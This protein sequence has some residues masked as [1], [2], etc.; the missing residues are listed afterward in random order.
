MAKKIIA[1]CIPFVIFFG[2]FWAF[3]YMFQT[4]E[5]YHK[6]LGKISK[7]YE[8]VGGGM[9]EKV[10]KPY[11]E[12]TNENMVQWDGEH[13]KEIRD[14]GYK[15]KAEV[16]LDYIFAFFPLFPFIW[17]I[18]M[19]SPIGV[20]FL[21]FFLFTAG[22]LILFFLFKKKISD[23]FLFLSLPLVVCFLVPHTEA[24]FFLMGA[25]ALLGHLKGKYWLYFLGMAL[26]ALTRNAFT[27]ILPAMICAEILFFLQ[28]RN[29]KSS[30][31]RLSKA[32]LPVITGTLVLAIIQYLQ[33]S[34][35]F[36]NFLT[37]QEQWGHSLS[38]P[39]L[40]KL[41]DWSHESFGI[42][43]PTLIIVGIPIVVY[44]GLIFLKQCRIIKSQ[45]TV[46]QIQDNKQ[47]YA[48][49]V[50]LFCC[51]A[52]ISFVLFF[53][54][55]NLHGLS[56]FILATPYFA[57]ALF[58]GFNKIKN[59]SISKRVITLVLLIIFSFLIFF[60]T[61]YTLFSFSYAGFFILVTTIGLYVLQDLS[62]SLIYKIILSTNFVC[63]IIFTTYLF[64]MYI[65]NGWLFL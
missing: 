36:L 64:N 32:V 43:V 28:N 14:N 65:S 31:I 46:F 26:V 57:V 4:P 59:I 53:Q 7:N 6:T 44:L 18:S 3:F 50:S 9:R 24:V 13:Y 33:G 34:S 45:D 40:L 29:T 39:N 5:I 21:N 55:G 1:L 15:K 62:S 49:L 54:K 63:N 8:Y 16:G 2:L 30:L 42:N 17:K 10:S 19:V 48:F 23:I 22:L 47:N 61:Q 56:R 51:V 35:S 11:L 20:I 52:A 58:L 25:I 37:V 12:I 41:G 38:L 27:L 60:F